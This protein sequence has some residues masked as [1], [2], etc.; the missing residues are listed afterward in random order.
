MAK[1]G[2][3]EV[4]GSLTG[5]E[6]QSWHSETSRSLRNQSPSLANL[7][8]KPVL[9]N[10]RIEVS[11]VSPDVINFVKALKGSGQS[12]DP[13][14]LLSSARDRYWVMLNDAEFRTPLPASSESP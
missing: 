1:P 8:L 9:S 11:R 2:R 13:R 6:R 4:H 5:Q 10:E 3:S 12:W 14:S 7:A